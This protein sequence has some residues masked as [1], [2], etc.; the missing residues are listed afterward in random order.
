VGVK[1]L[2]AC[3]LRLPPYPHLPPRR[4]EGAGCITRELC[5][6]VVWFDLEGMPPIHASLYWS[7]ILETKPHGVRRQ[8]PHGVYRCGIG[9][10][11]SR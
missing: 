9:S 2:A 5:L 10:T 6:N 1:R 11:L 3:Y 8:H 7:F 4:G